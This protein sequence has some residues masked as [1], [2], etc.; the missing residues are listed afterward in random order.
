MGM[1]TVTAQPKKEKKEPIYFSNE[2]IF[3]LQIKAGDPTK[4]I[5]IIFFLFWE[6]CILLYG[7]IYT[8]KS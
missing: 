3:L 5:L 1:V 4:S 7:S 8:V 2:S 6:P